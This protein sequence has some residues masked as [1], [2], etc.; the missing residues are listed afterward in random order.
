MSGWLAG[1]AGHAHCV[2]DCATEAPA[3]PVSDPNSVLS[4]QH[5]IASAGQTFALPAQE[6]NFITPLPAPQSGADFMGPLLRASTAKTDY[7]YFRCWLRVRQAPAARAGG[8][9]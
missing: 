2:Q 6:C 9:Q 8:A 3:G 5:C 1:T 4:G 7:G